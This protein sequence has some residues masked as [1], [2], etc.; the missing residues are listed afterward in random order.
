MLYDDMGRVDGYDVHYHGKDAMETPN[1]LTSGRG[2]NTYKDNK[3]TRQ[4]HKYVQTYEKGFKKRQ[5][6]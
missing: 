4:R 1:Y 3:H 2:T 5:S 6:M